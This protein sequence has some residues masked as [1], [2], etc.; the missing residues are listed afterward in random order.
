MNSGMKDI[1]KILEEELASWFYGVRTWGLLNGLTNEE[2]CKKEAHGAAET[3]LQKIAI[4]SVE[5]KVIKKG[6]D[7]KAIFLI[8]GDVD[9]EVGDKEILLIVKK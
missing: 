3:I 5:A 2:F 1:K 6:T 8:D 7:H 4:E 9:L